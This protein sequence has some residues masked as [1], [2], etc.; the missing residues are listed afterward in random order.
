M[1]PRI[2][3]ILKAKCLITLVFIL[4]HSTHSANKPLLLMQ[5]YI[6]VAIFSYV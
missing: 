6:Y 3:L 4:T 1:K 5:A 2:M